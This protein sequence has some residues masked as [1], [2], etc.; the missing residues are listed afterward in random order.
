MGDVPTEVLNLVTPEMVR[1]AARAVAD[2]ATHAFGHSTFYDVVLPDGRRVP[3]KA[4]FGV[5][6][7]NIIGRPAGP[8][9]FS[10]GWAHPAYNIMNDAG[11]EIVPKGGQ[12]EWDERSW[13]EGS[14]KAKTHF[15]KERSRSM[16]RAFK[17]EF[18]VENGG[19]F[20]ERCGLDPITLGEFGDSCIEV[21]HA[22]PPVSKM[23]PGHCTTFK[24]LMCICANCHRIVH[25]EMAA[26]EK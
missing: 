18:R 16:I 26:Y 24:D 5:A 10:S 1:E 21:H 23:K 22:N 6:L 11:L 14:L 12:P 17:A 19:L 20:C 7:A 25:R 2:G 15:G 8:K 3:P 13:E 9:D 4:V